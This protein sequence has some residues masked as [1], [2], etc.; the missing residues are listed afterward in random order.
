MEFS[1]KG[2]QESVSFTVRVTNLSD[3]PIQS[4]TDDRTKGSFTK[5]FFKGGKVTVFEGTVEDWKVLGSHTLVIVTRGEI[6][7]M[8]E[9]DFSMNGKDQIERNIPVSLWRLRP[10]P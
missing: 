8:I 4:L 6:D 5:P 2:V 9:L 10:L 3:N 7:A 1:V